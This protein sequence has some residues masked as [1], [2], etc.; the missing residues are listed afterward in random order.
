STAAN[1]IY[2]VDTNAQNVT[3][4]ANLTSSGGT[5]TKLG[6]GTLTLNGNN[7]YNGATTI[8]AGTLQLGNNNALAGTSSVTDNGNLTFNSANIT[9][10]LAI[11]GFGSV[12]VA[13]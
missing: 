8:T 5:L 3:W 7:T 1:Q 10:G 13:G 11:T 12:T 6:A 9:F 4:N 2:R